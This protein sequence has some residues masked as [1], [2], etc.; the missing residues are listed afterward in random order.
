[1]TEDKKIVLEPAAQ[2]FADD[3]SEP[4]FLPDLGP[5]K[6]RET[7]NTVQSSEIFKPEADIQDL[8]V[9]G[10]PGG[11]VKVRIV[12]PIGSASTSLPVIL[13]IHG[14]GW[15][16]GNSHTHDRLIR[17][18]AVGAEAAVVFPEYSLSPEA[19]YPTA[20]EE[21][22]AVL[23]WIA[24][25]GS[26]Y[27]LDTS[28]LSVAGDSVGGNMTAA[29][30]L[31]AKER[32]GPAISKQLLFYPVTDAA[33]DTESYHLF[34]EGYFLQRT[35]MKWFWDQYTTDPEERAQ[36]TASPLRASL[37]Q[38]SG[39]PEALII[40]GEADVLRDEGEAY[41]AKLREAGVPVTAVRFQGIIHDFVMLNALAETHAKKGA[42]LLATAWL[43]Q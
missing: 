29:I 15:V 16:F 23:E 17:E 12:R 42:L 7:V 18:L 21:I 33:F 2:K 9:S 28:K 22:Y 14:A 13:Y 6:G 30:T 3:N 38:L 10:G 19:K 24:Q 27:G 41:A 20:I 35:G 1:M 37:E 26:T 31:M 11:E 5:E 8:T 34:A 43:K 39:L 40:T 4:P 36:I 25:E 32:S